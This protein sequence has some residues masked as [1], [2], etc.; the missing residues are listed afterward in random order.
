[1]SRNQLHDKILYTVA[2]NPELIGLDLEDIVNIKT[3]VQ[4]EDCEADVLFRTYD[5]TICVEVK[6][7]DCT[8]CESK[9][10]NQLK[11]I[12]RHHDEESFEAYGV[13]FSRES[14]KYIVIKYY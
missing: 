4:F 13:F 7:C 3:K 5:D 2:A 12:R 6:S 10:Q 11:R 1:M 8:N 14:E 9:A